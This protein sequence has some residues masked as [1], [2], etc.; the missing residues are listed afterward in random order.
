[1]VKN[2]VIRIKKNDKRKM[3]YQ[4]ADVNALFYSPSTASLKLSKNKIDAIVKY[5]ELNLNG[6]GKSST[7]YK[8]QQPSSP[9]IIVKCK[10]DIVVIESRGCVLLN[11]LGEGAYGKVYKAVDLESGKYVAVKAQPSQFYDII[12]RQTKITRENGIGLH[13]PLANFGPTFLSDGF[14]YFI[15]PLADYALYRWAIIQRK[16]CKGDGKIVNALIK[17]SL[18]LENLHLKR[19]VHMDLKIDNALVVNDRV[20]LSDF[21][22]VEDEGA[23]VR[24]IQADYRNYPHCAPEYFKNGNLGP[25]YQISHCFDLYSFGY[26]IKSMSA[27]IGSPSI[28]EELKTLSLFLMNTIPSQRMDLK[29]ARIELSRIAGKCR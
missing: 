18:D 13:D 7:P 14:G 4:K 5:I 16:S 22:K 20:Y 6:K 23:V 3:S 27:F 10:Y 26:L 11:L 21:G 12:K 9:S 8:L 15:L 25:S 28:Q 17:I 24:V 1:M 29:K 19:K 2:K